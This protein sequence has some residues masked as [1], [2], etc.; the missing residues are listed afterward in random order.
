MKRN[1][2]NYLPNIFK[3]QVTYTGQNLSTQFKVKD[4]IKFE[5]KYDIIYFSKCPEKKYTDN[6]LGKSVRKISE[7]II[8]HG[9]KDKN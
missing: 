4:R 6:Y 8:D 9:G 2:N 7:R 5:D 3:T 1:L